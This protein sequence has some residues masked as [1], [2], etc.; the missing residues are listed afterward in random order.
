M[1]PDVKHL[2]EQLVAVSEVSV[3]AALGYPKSLCQYFN[4]H[5]GNTVGFQD[6]EGHVKPLRLAD[7][8]RFFLLL[9]HQV[10]YIYID[11]TV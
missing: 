5:P 10:I 2:L 9:W 11:G 1:G 3:K 6:I 8:S 7:T 4:T